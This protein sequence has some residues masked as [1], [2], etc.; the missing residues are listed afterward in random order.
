MRT[1]VPANCSFTGSVTPMDA[2]SNRMIESDSSSSGGNN[3]Y[4]NCEYTEPTMTV[5][6][7]ARPCEAPVFDDI[8]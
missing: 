8:Q 3:P 2:S 1:I 4:T 5:A 6:K 7:A